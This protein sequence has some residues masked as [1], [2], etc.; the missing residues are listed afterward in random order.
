MAYNKKKVWYSQ[1]PA[2]PKWVMN[3]VTS[4]CIDLGTDMGLV[5]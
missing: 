1:G 3:K 2:I 4:H 5:V